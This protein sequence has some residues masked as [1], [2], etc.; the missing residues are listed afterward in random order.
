VTIDRTS[1]VVGLV[2]AALRE[3]SYVIPA[4][5][6]GVQIVVRPDGLLV[7][8]N[9]FTPL[10]AVPAQAVY[11]ST[12]TPRF[13]AGGG[14]VMDNE[15]VLTVASAADCR[16]AVIPHAALA[17]LR[18]WA[19]VAIVHNAALRAVLREPVVMSRTAWEAPDT[20]EDAR[21]MITRC[22]QVFALQHRTM[23]ENPLVGR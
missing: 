5:G 17:P 19:Y 18:T 8:E 12:E 10:E 23:Y 9:P 13:G 4:D 6:G 11:P 1:L 7:S 2:A 21:T 15:L 22:V 3:P 16:G 14:G 20:D